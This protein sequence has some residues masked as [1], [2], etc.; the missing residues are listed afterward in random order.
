MFSATI[1]TARVIF[2]PAPDSLPP[3][4]REKSSSNNILR[5]PTKPKVYTENIIDKKDLSLT[6]P[7]LSS[8]GLLTSNGNTAISTSFTSESKLFNSSSASLTSAIFA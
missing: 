4:S 8:V 3:L 6:S 5:F 1:I 7:S 2:F